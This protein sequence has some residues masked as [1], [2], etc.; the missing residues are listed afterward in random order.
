MATTA[1]AALILILV[2]AVLRRFGLVRPED[3]SVLVRIVIYAAT[4]ALILQILLRTDLTATLVVVPVIAFAVHGILVGLALLASRAFRLDRPRT[5][6]MI[7]ATAVGNTGFFGVP[8]IANS[9]PGFSPAAAIMYDVLATGLITWVSTPAVGS[10]YGEGGDQR[11]DWREIRRTLL[12]PPNWA[13]AAGII[14]NLSGVHHMPDAVGRP[15]GFLAAAVLPLVMLYVGIVVAPRGI[16][17]VWPQVATVVVIRLVVAAAIGFALG[18]A[19]GLRG[20]VLHTVVLMAAMPTAIMSLVIGSGE[21]KLNADIV[22]GSILTT[23][24]LCT[25]TLPLIRAI[26]V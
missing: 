7:V 19:V 4:P 18:Y 6:A 17:R 25:A 24:L 14:L 2:G 20:V 13:L 15:V 3:G 26:L 9:G 12:L 1:F 5:G 21:Y 8:L 16:H 22:A 11:V 23:T 10:A